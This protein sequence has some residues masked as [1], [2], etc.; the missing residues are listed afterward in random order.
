MKQRYAHEPLKFS[1]TDLPAGGNLPVELFESVSENLLQNVLHKRQLQHDTS[2][3]ASLAWRDSGYV[4]T[5]CDDGEA[6]ADSVARQLFNAPV[7]SSNVGLGVGL[8]QASRFAKEHKHVL[9]LLSN[10]NGK[11][12]FELAPA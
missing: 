12:C 9:R 1:E 10:E 2:I 3:T 4:L 7:S 6:V 5:V 8:Y 11:V